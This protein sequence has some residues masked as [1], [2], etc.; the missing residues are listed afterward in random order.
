M[1]GYHGRLAA[2][3]FG[4]HG[5]IHLFQRNRLFV[6]W[7]A[8]ECRSIQAGKALE[9]LERL[10]FIK[11]RDIAF[12]GVG[13]VEDPRTATIAFLRVAMMGRAISAQE[14]FLRTRRCCLA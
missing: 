13:C 4:R 8:V 11:N 5:N 12:Q 10:F 1:E 6:Y 7:K 9:V 14:V 2:I 3:D